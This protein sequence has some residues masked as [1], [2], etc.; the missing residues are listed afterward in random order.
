MVSVFWISLILVG[1]VA[2]A[3]IAYVIAPLRKPSLPLRAEEDDE[4]ADLMDR[5]DETLRS[6]KEVEFD[7]HTG[8]LSQDD[9]DRYDQ[10][11]RQQAVGLMRQIEVRSPDLA[12]LDASLEAAIVAQRQVSTPVAANGDSPSPDSSEPAAT[13]CH[14]CGAKAKSDDRFCAKCGT[15]LRFEQG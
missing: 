11:L 10:R 7:Y 12:G 2:V 15:E 8:K 13:F 5:K 4:L 14:S 9:Y 6:I 3:A 1:A